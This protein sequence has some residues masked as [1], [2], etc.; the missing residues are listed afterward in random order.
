M[1]ECWENGTVP[2]ILFFRPIIPVFQY[3]VSL[4]VAHQAVVGHFLCGVAVHAPP[5]RHF[6]PWLVRGVIAL[7]D[8]PMA[9]LTFEFP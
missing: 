3:S 8:I 4:Y 6:H 7:A 5:H 2:E 9:L 1:M